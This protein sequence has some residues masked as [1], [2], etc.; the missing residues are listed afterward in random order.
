MATVTE[1]RSVT[2]SGLNYIDSL[3]GNLPNWNYQTSGGNTLYY[4]FSVASNLE[5]GNT[6]L[7]S[8]PMMFT[9]AQQAATRGAMAYAAKLTGINFV[10]T[11]DANLAQVHFAN[12][13]ISGSYTSGLTSS[14]YSY[15]YY[16]TGEV[17]KFAASPYVYLDNKEWAAKNANLAAGTQGYETLLHEIGHMLG[18]KHPFEGTTRLPTAD[19]HTG[20]TLMSYTHAGGFHSTFSEYD[21]AALKWLYGGDGLAGALGVN[22]TTGGRY[23]AGT[24]LANTLTG[25]AANDKLEGN[26]GNDVL[27]GG[28][29]TDIA[30][31][32]GLSTA[33]AL[34]QTGASSWRVSGSEGIDTLSNIEMLQFADRTISLGGTS[35]ATM[36]VAPAV[37][38]VDEPV[39]LVGQRGHAH[40][41]HVDHAWV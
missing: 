24:S 41:H 18:L 5:T 20:H 33:Y 11:A 6:A 8:K 17:S 31:F 25:T 14:R 7:L 16:S 22:S 35:L 23:F 34:V 13:D 4:S 39:Q 12:A 30:V 40:G 15:S 10:E 3:L 32:N 28:A 27:N 36:A 9:T 19:D 26:G 1:V 21:V 38:I 29:G 37:E 2:L